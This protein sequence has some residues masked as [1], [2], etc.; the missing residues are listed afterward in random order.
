[1]GVTNV[2]HLLMHSIIARCQAAYESMLTKVLRDL[3]RGSI[4]QP[5][6]RAG[7]S[8]I[9]ML[10]QLELIVVKSYECMRVL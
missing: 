6:H 2:F 8:I 3:P 10:P 5:G 7:E 4:S 9:F 1:M